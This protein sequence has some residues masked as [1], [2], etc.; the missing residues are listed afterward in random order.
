MNLLKTYKPTYP[1]FGKHIKFIYK[2][3]A[4]THSGRDTGYLKPSAYSL[5]GFKDK[6]KE[7]TFI[8]IRTNIRN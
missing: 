5:E 7:G 6:V 3:K 8:E 1:T 2:F 4:Y